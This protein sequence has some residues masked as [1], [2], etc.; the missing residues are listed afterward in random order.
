VAFLLNHGIH[1]KRVSLFSSVWSVC[2]VVK[3]ESGP[4]G[5]GTAPQTV[6][7]LRLRSEHLSL[8]KTVDLPAG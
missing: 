3:P 1:G 2:S 4:R 8:S 7:D 5:C 6:R